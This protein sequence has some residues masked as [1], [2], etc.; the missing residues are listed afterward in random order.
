MFVDPERLA[1]KTL[2]NFINIKGVKLSKDIF[3]I[4]T[5]SH[6]R[7]SLGYSLDS[8]GKCDFANLLCG[9]PILTKLTS[10]H[11]TL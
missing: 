1:F 5:I 8:P 9:K 6:M 3:I 2:C 11:L 4:K 7:F 10:L